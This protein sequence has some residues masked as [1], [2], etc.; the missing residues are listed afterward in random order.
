MN[1]LDRHSTEIS[2]NLDHTILKGGQGLYYLTL[3]LDR[4]AGSEMGLFFFFSNF[5]PGPAGPGYAFPLQTV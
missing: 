1:I 2:V 4:S 5:N 3:F